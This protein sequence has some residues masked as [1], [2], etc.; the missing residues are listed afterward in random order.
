MCGV[1]AATTSRIRTRGPFCH[2]FSVSP[3]GPDAASTADSESFRCG[4]SFAVQL[5]ELG[6]GAIAANRQQLCEVVRVEGGLRHLGTSAVGMRL[7]TANAIAVGP[8]TQ[9]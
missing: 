5:A 9:G 4:E 8:M 3:L 7:H 1:L 6:L 2:T